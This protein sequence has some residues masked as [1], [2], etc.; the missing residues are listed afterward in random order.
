MQ[1]VPPGRETVQFYTKVDFATGEAPAVHGLCS[2]RDS[3]RRDIQAELTGWPYREPFAP[4]PAPSEKQEKLDKRLGFA[5]QLLGGILAAVTQLNGPGT[6]GPVGTP[7]QLPDHSDDPA[8]EVE[9][10]P[11]MWAD[12]GTIAR[13][14]PWQLD[15]W[16]SGH[17]YQTLL[18]VTERGMFVLGYDKRTEAPEELLWQLPL[19]SVRSIR[20]LPYCLNGLDVRIDFEDDS[21]TRLSF[22]AQCDA[23]RI[24]PLVRRTARRVT[25][26]ELPEPQRA[27]V[28][29]ALASL[30]VPPGAEP[31]SLTLMPSGF[32]VVGNHSPEHGSRGHTN[33][34]RCVSPEGERVSTPPDDLS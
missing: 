9:D 28:A 16:R 21:W 27:G 31:P 14:L 25:E 1:W 22:G 4:R 12:P 8:N 26:A 3:Q 19:S 32:V 20:R 10:F 30:H 29:K 13:G 11:V 5:G 33:Q 17:N 2:F 23:Q 6:N 34:Y 7:G 18:A 15:P 24:V